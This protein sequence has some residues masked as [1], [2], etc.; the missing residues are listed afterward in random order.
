MKGKPEMNELAK[1]ERYEVSPWQSYADDVLASAIAGDM[2]KF[3]KGD[4]LRGEGDAEVPSD[5]M[6]VANMDEVWTGWVR[7]FD[8]NPA[9][10]R[11]SRLI[12]R[13]PKLMREDLGYLDKATWETNP[14]GTL[15]DPWAPTDR[16]VMKDDCTDELVTFVTGSY[17]GRW[18]LAKLLR[19][20]DRERT[21][22]QGRFPVL[23]LGVDKTWKHDKFGTIPR[24]LFNVIGW[25]FWDRDA[26]PPD[27][28][29]I[30]APTDTAKRA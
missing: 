19:T 9:E 17:G 28:P 12:D 15:R 21:R 4:W 18:A 24:P 11:I 20:Y 26:A 7:W 1:I 30:E 2:L 10:H 3:V 29:Q 6:F 13:Q 5:A 14:D 25:R 8:G 22:Q 23:T 16:L 27:S